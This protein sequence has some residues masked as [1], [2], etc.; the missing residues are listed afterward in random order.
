MKLEIPLHPLAQ[1]PRWLAA[2]LLAFFVVA[3]AWNAVSLGIR[4]TAHVTDIEQRLDRGE[5]VDMDLYRQVHA[6][7]ARGEDYYSA[8]LQGNRDFTFPTRP[9][10][11]VRTPVLAWGAA[12][13]GDYGW[14]VIAAIL[15]GANAV[16]WVFALKGQTAPRERDAALTLS[17]LM[18]AAAFIPEVAF[19]HELQGGL[20]ISLALAL[21]ATRWWIGALVA[22]V[23]GIA[24]RELAAPFLLAW[25]AIAL[26]SGRRREFIGVLVAGAL[27]ALG[28]WLHARGVAGARLPGDETSPGWMGMFGPSLPLY[29]IH[30]TTLFQ[31]LPNWLAGPL[32]VLPLLGWIALGGRTG[33]LATLWFAGFMAAVA[34]FARQENFYWMGLFVPAYGVGLAFVPRA[35]RDLWRSLKPSATASPSSA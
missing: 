32:G 22:A 11:T 3:G 33:A 30:V 34:I 5:K 4:D 8:A 14:R 16:A 26:A 12:L 27:V 20:L 2:M 7:V 21:S 1:A 19:S 9:F 15:W 23:L 6:A 35:A 25:A 24:V 13:W 18:G 17:L 10:V 31:V 28:L 29:G